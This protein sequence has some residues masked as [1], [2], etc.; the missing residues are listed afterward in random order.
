MPA[1]EKLG[2]QFHYDDPESLGSKQTHRVR[3]MR[4]DEKVGHLSWDRKQVV[5]IEVNEP[6]QGIGTALW[7]EGQRL[8]S[9]NRRIPAPKHSA[10]R[11]NSGDAWAKSVGGPLPR[12]K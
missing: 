10:Y 11:T 1:H 7:H 9:E 2:I 4:G 5:N 8:A 6:R 3:A 12:R